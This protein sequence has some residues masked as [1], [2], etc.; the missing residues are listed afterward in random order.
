MQ[1]GLNESSVLIA[2]THTESVIDRSSPYNIIETST[3]EEDD[4]TSKSLDDNDEVML[5]E[6]NETISPS[7][8]ITS[9]TDVYMDA[10]D[11]LN[12]QQ[13]DGSLTPIYYGSF[14]KEIIDSFAANLH[15][16]DKDVA[17]CDRNYSYFINLNNLKKLRN[18]MCT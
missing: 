13:S 5:T 14:S 8:S 1:E 11:A 15:R 18:I 4:I 12:D 6:Q 7:S 3:D 9:G 2:R 10:I 16:I 17:R